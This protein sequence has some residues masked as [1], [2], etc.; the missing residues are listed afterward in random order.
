M[1][2]SAL[3]KKLKKR[4]ELYEGNVPHMYLDSKGYVTIGI[5]SLI[6]SVKAAQKL[7]FVHDKTHKKATANEIQTDY[8]NVLKANSLKLNFQAS[9]YK[10]FT[11]LKLKQNT[12]DKL[13]TQHVSNFHTEL[14]R[15]Y[16]QFNHYPVEVKLI[17]FDMVYNMGITKL[18]KQFPKFNKAIIN[19][20]WHKAAN[21]SHRKLPISSKRNNYVKNLLLKT[22][23]QNKVVQI[24]P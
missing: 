4:I 10:R 12:I 19:M 15:L 14:K 6:P 22:A 17:L 24:T 23:K 9:Y 13:F 2:S 16:P 20:D 5:G 1:I 8:N 11:H 21:E 18:K 7:P 3:A